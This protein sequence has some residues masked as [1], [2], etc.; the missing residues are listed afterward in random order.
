MEKFIPD[1]YLLAKLSFRVSFSNNT[2]YILN[3]LIRLELNSKRVA[4]LDFARHSNKM[5]VI[6]CRLRHHVNTFYFYFIDLLIFYQ[7]KVNLD[8]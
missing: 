8:G 2:R 4:R 6:L 1:S 3:Y 7:K 5:S